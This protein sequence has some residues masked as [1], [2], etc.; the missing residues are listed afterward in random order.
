M[1]PDA[2]IQRL[3]P[4]PELRRGVLLAAF[5]G[6][7]DAGD[8]ASG[9]VDALA[10][11]VDA[12]AVAQIDP[13]EFF[14]FQVSR[15]TIRTDSDGG[16]VIS[17]PRNQ[18]LHADVG[19]RDLLL[20]SGREPNVRWR[21]FT[22]TVLG[23]AEDLGVTRA[24]FVG[25]LQ[26]DTPHTRP[27]PLSGQDSGDVLAGLGVRPSGYEG[28]TG[29]TGVLTD[30]ASTRGFETAS[31]WAGVPHYLSATSYASAAHALATVITRALDIDVDLE[32]L[33]DAAER[34]QTEIAEVVTA[35]DD[36]AEYV[37]ELEER[38]DSDEDLGSALR[39]LH[40]G[41][42]TADELGAA[43]ER[44]LRERDREGREGDS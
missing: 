12:T 35:D 4:D 40:A 8:A 7:N 33:S 42:V 30:A 15:P 18:F 28:P 43:F 41:R 21:A 17:W 44:Y 22:E 31:L 2:V 39:D 5:A 11:L 1:D 37:A 16:R 27:V 23:Y 24:I 20:L 3:A 26:L 36:L 10:H 38:V 25:A 13:E 34:Q 9:A 6:W 29:I 19:D 32:P 14:D